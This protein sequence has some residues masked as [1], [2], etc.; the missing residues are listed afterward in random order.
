MYWK[1][2]AKIALWLMPFFLL[3][4]IVFSA[5][6]VYRGEIILGLQAKLIDNKDQEIKI[7]VEHQEAAERI[8][9]DYE[10]RKADRE[11]DK[12]NAK[13]TIE[14]VISD[15]D[16]NTVCFDNAWMYQLNSQIA[17]INNTRKPETGMPSSTGA[18]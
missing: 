3:T 8:S 4:S 15:S 18:N 11:Q 13:I 7:I 2:Y 6:A 12:A 1:L 5:I 16:N 9:N 10:Q 17:T 14:K